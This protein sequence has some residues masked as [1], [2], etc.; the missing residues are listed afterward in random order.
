MTHELE[1]NRW[2][3]LPDGTKV[4]SRCKSGSAWDKMSCPA[5][6]KDN[7]YIVD[8]EFANERMHFLDGVKIQSKILWSDDCPST[9]NREWTDFDTN[10]SNNINGSHN[11][12]KTIYR[13]K[14]TMVK[15]YLVAYKTSSMEKW[16]ITLGYFRDSEEYL[17]FADCSQDELKAEIIESSVKEFDIQENG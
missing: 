5:F 10:D 4:W 2:A 16:E 11:G 3:K 6:H 15:K 8:D 7:L 13:I 9:W 14:P 17:N 1:I 12:T